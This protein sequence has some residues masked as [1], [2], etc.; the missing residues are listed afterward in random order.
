MPVVTALLHDKKPESAAGML[1]VKHGSGL[2]ILS[3]VPFP[4]DDEHDV[5]RCFWTQ[6]ISNIGGKFSSTILDGDCV[7]PGSM[8][9]DG[10]PTEFGFIINPDDEELKNILKTS[11]P[12]EYSIH[13]HALVYGYDWDVSEF[14]DGVFRIDNHNSVEKVIIAFQINAGRPRMIRYAEDG[15]PDPTEQTLCE[16]KGHGI[17]TPYINGRQFDTITLG[18]A[19]H[20]VIP[21]IDLNMDW[22]TIVLIWEPQSSELAISWRD[23]QRHPEVEFAFMFKNTKYLSGAV[24]Q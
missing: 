4:L 3:Q 17:I 23:R 19:G 22:N 18:S 24:H 8:R 16:I 15:L 7:R 14:D 13:N 2:L 12:T 11:R 1:A 5:A 9:S 20:G 6:F 21:D 10:F